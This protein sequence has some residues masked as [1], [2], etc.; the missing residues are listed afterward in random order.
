MRDS[1]PRYLLHP[2]GMGG[3]RCWENWNEMNKCAH[4]NQSMSEPKRKLD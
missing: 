2:G 3:S 1:H 4:K